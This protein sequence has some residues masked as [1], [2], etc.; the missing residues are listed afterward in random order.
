M[1][2]YNINII[3]SF[4]NNAILRKRIYYVAEN[5]KWVIRQV[6]EYVIKNLNKTGIK[7]SL[8]FT[9]KFI[10][11]SIVHF[12]SLNVFMPRLGYVNL[13]QQ[14]NKTVVTCFHLVPQDPRVKE[15]SKAKDFVDL[16]H[17]A[18]SLTKADMIMAGIPKDKISVICLGIDLGLFRP[19]SNENRV[20]L[21]KKYR[22]P[23]KSIVIGSFQKDGVGWGDG[24]E[25]KKIKGPDIF[26]EAVAAL[27]KKYP[28]FVFITGPARGFVKK[29]LDARRIPYRHVYTR[30]SELPKF[31]NMLDLYLVTSRVEGLPKSILECMATSTPFVTT[32]VGIAPDVVVNTVNGFICDIEDIEGIIARARLLIEDK[33]VRDSICAAMQKTIKDY[34][35]DKVILR[36]I[37][38][39]YSKL[40]PCQKF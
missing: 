9:P 11:Q 4:F 22:I 17:T 2:R 3:K 20:L 12:G 21:R 35:W 18:S 8:T 26:C 13:P 32:R 24:N 40:I 25:P 33:T 34:S 31:Y 37:D 39:I 23:E 7:S 27:A 29:Q 5:E 38:S 14:G 15:L 19:F 1:V 6:G 36:Y 30:Y 16:W 28:V 10:K